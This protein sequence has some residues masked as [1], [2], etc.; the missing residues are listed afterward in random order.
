[1]GETAKSTKAVELAEP[2][3]DC[4]PRYHSLPAQSATLCFSG[5]PREAVH[6]VIRAR[7]GRWIRFSP[8]RRTGFAAAR[9]VLAKFCSPD[10]ARQIEYCAGTVDASVRATPHPRHWQALAESKGVLLSAIGTLLLLAH[11]DLAACGLTRFNSDSTI[12]KCILPIPTTQKPSTTMWSGRSCP[13]S[14]SK[15][16]PSAGSSFTWG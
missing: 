16:R 2:Q 6:L 1:M 11:P 14:W 12:E 13:R 5:A 3:K 9:E 10:I 15:T 8:R 7:P 4:W